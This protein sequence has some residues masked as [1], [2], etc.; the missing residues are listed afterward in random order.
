MIGDVVADFQLKHVNG[1]TVGLPDYRTQKGLIVV[2]TSNHC[3]FAKAYENRIQELDRRYAAQGF[4]V[5][6]IMPNDPTVYEDDSFEA[7]KVRA[8]E[9]AYSF[10]YAIDETQTTARAFGATR[11]PQVFVLKNANSQFVLEY[12]GAID[13][14]PQD[15]T[16]I[17]RRYVEEAVN[18]LLEGRP[19]QSPITKPI[20]CA[21]KWR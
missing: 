11:T 1:Q 7:M 6:A 8:A 13:D 21:I 15:T 14:N 19:V 2:F 3:P 16:G 4:P 9:K 17:Q 20:G 5:L 18:Y 10:A 12:V